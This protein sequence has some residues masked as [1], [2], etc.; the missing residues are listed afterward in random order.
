MLPP[1][2]IWQKDSGY[3][4]V[5]EDGIEIEV[6]RIIGYSLNVSLD[7]Q[8]SGR[9]AYRNVT[10]SIYTGGYATYSS[11]I[12]YITE[13]IRSYLTVHFTSY[14]PCFVKYRRWNRFFKIF[15]VDM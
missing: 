15:S 6:L 3:Q 11:V 2:T 14:T 4:D 1:K 12:D 7:I 10:A 8:E 13:Q 5:Y 9:I